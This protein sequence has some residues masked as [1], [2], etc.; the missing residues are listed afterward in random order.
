MKNVDIMVYR[1][2]LFLLEGYSVTSARTPS[3]SLYISG[4]PR[5]NLSGAVFVFVEPS[6]NSIQTLP[7]EQVSDF[8]GSD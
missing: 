1:T 6:Q 7:G 8:F 4:A 5:H 3:F 2:V